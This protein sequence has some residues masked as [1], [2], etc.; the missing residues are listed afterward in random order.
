MAHEPPERIGAWRRN[1]VYGA[2]GTW[3]FEHPDGVTGADADGPTDGRFYAY[4][5]DTG[6][7]LANET[8]SSARA[9][10]QH[11][12]WWMKRYDRGKGGVGGAANAQGAGSIPNQGSV[13]DAFDFGGGF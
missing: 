7:Q 13:D 5:P 4:V 3:R 6:R 9:A 11:A 10:N 8:F 1:S 12:V 2:P